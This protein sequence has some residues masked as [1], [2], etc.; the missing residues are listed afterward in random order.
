MNWPAAW[1]LIGGLILRL[2]IF[3]GNPPLNAFDDHFTPIALLIKNGGLVGKFDCWECYHPPVFYVLSALVAKVLI[4]LHFHQS[5]ILKLLQFLNCLYGILTLWVIYL[6]LEKLPLSRFARLLA[7]G[8]ACFLPR[9]IYMGALHSNDTFSYLMVALCVYLLL[10][11]VVDGKHAVPHLLLLGT[12]LSAAIFSKYTALAVLPVAAASFACLGLPGFSLSRVEVLKKGAIALAV[13]TLL[14]AGSMYSNYQAYGAALP[15]NTRLF[16]PAGVQAR[17]PGGLEFA[18]F[19]PWRFVEK[20]ILWPGQLNSFWTLI[21]SSMW[22]DSEPK[23]L[24]VLKGEDQ[25]WWSA[26]YGWLNGRNSAPPSYMEGKPLIWRTGAILIGCGVV[27]VVLVLAGLVRFLSSIR[28]ARAVHDWRAVA[29]N[30]M[31]V[32]LLMLNAAGVILVALNTPVFSAMKASYFLPSLPAFAVL[33]GAGIT[34]WERHRVFRVGSSLYFGVL[35]GLVF[36]NT[37]MIAVK[38]PGWT[39]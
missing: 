15:S 27:P 14:L 35:F 6:V 20:P 39:G 7:F 9:D 18:T 5:N 1:L 4:Y 11:V 12:V 10:R 38:L 23:F 31:F 17:D 32:L 22:F 21:H 8:F 30:Q 28:T 37:L 33:L 29:A 13:P 19:E 3:W 16:D 25:P 2:A 26:Y 36:L 34:Q 24:P